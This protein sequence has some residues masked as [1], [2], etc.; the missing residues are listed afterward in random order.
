M[1]PQRGH[2]VRD[3][4]DLLGVSGVCTV[5]IGHHRKPTIRSAIL[6]GVLAGLGALT[7]SEIS[8]LIPGFAIVSALMCRRRGRP[9][10]PAIAILLAG[11]ATLLPWSIY[12]ANR[13]DESVFLSTNDGSTLLGANCDGSYYREIG[14][15]DLL[16]LGPL[17]PVGIGHEPGEPDAS[18]RSLARRRTR[19]RLHQLQRRA[20]SGR[21]GGTSR[22][23]LDVYG[24]SSSSRTIVGDDKDEWVSWAG[25]VSFWV[26]TPL[27]VA[28]WMVLSRRK[29]GARWWLLVPVVQVFITVVLYYG[30]HRLRAAAEPTVVL[31]AAVALVMWWERARSSRPIEE[32]EPIDSRIIHSGA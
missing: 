28:G 19:T 26:L 17:E 24:L 1:D 21:D 6:L 20:A 11:I 5:A 13:F 15:W 2:H 18:E 27:A 8:L 16:C 7:R 25:I 4:R 12:N 9:I 23:T 3:D 14:G 32:D 10:W 22:R 29:V 31:L 30:S